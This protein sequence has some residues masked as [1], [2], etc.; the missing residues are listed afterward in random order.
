MIYLKN[1]Q[2]LDCMRKAGALLYEVLCR[3]KEAAKPGVS[4]AALDVYAEQLIRKH[5]AVP[6]FLDYQGYP[7]SICAS[8]NDEVVHGIPSEEKMLREGDILSVDCGLVLDGWQAD[9]AFTIGIGQ[10]SA[11]KQQLID[12]T[13]ES[14]FR[15]I[16][17]AIAGNQLGDI[18]HAVQSYAESFGYG[19]VRDLTGHGIGRNM[20]EEPSVPNFGREGHGIR[21]RAGMTLAI[22][23]M[24]A[25]GDY[26]V[27]ELEDGWTIVTEDGS[28]CSHYEHTIAI[29]EKGLPELLTYPGFALT[30]EA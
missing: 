28:P 11:E 22:E 7:A 8:I 2:Q 26:H 6:S 17:K 30:E 10:I 16:R 23:P 19:V 24:I 9:S 29:N 21:L 5:K 15:G 4:T 3:I 14:F 20:H 27:A 18:G 25:M 13:E 1:P 12:V